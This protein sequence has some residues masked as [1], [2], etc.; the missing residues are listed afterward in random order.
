MR[1]CLDIEVKIL[2]DKITLQSSFIDT[3]FDVSLSP[4]IEFVFRS[5]ERQESLP[6][7][8]VSYLNYIN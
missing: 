4:F 3:K 5:C 8:G 1:I 6:D 2:T 7:C